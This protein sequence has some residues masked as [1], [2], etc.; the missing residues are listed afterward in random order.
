MGVKEFDVLIPLE[1]GAVEGEQMLEA[2]PQHRGDE[3]RVVGIP[4]RGE[5]GRKPLP[6][7]GREDEAEP[8]RAVPSTGFVRTLYGR[9]RTVEPNAAHANAM[10][11]MLAG[12]G[13]VYSSNA[14]SLENWPISEG[15]SHGG[16]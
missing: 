2:V 8:S 9:R 3:S 12:S 10:R 4:R 7:A 1:V 5:G 15:P 13:I 16:R 11:T 6:G 14:K